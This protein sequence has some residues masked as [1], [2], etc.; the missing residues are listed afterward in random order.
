MAAA[1]CEAH[2]CPSSFN[3][4]SP[5]ALS[6]YITDTAKQELPAFAPTER[7]C[8][9]DAATPPHT[10]LPAGARLL[11]VMRHGEGEHNLAARV[12][13][14]QAYKDVQYFD[15]ALNVQGEAQASEAGVWTSLHCNPDVIL[16]S[17]LVRAMR[18]AELGFCAFA[19]KCPW[20][21]LNELREQCGLHPCDGR[22]PRSALGT[23][24]YHTRR[25]TH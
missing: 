7:F 19:A 24:T 8:F 13:G 11:Y 10:G 6:K 4:V 23:H 21:C 20:V 14:Y 25:P 15:A 3:P 18:T 16:V 12:S 1:S 2:F 5:R 17:P 9:C 22:K